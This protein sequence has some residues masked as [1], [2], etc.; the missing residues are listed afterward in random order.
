MES[1]LSGI[2]WIGSKMDDGWLGACRYRDSPGCEITAAS[3]IFR[4][5]IVIDEIAL[6]ELQSAGLQYRLGFYL[7]S[8]APL[9]VL[10]ILA[11]EF[12]RWESI[13]I[14]RTSINQSLSTP[15]GYQQAPRVFFASQ[16]LQTLLDRIDRRRPWSSYC[17]INFGCVWLAHFHARIRR[18][19]PG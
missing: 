10:F 14:A 17:R 18:L 9:P 16:L 3:V 2:L 11:F 7:D 19:S 8:R 15:C 12:Y 13:Q 1:M 5:R 6:Q 4:K